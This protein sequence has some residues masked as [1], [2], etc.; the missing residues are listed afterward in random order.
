M[1]WCIGEKGQLKLMQLHLK[2][3]YWLCTGQG[4]AKWTLEAQFGKNS[5]SMLPLMIPGWVFSSSDNDHE[6]N[7]ICQQQL[8]KPQINIRL[9]QEKCIIT[10]GT[11]QEKKM[12]SESEV[13]VRL[14]TSLT[15]QVLREV[16]SSYPNL[17]ILGDINIAKSAA[18]K[19][20]WGEG[21]ESFDQ[22]P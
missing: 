20:R 1:Q 17:T 8:K 2:L 4:L 22:D 7:A 16:R 19:T 18:L 11:M 15:C 13:R 3:V 6:T 21:H 12:K 14:D 10:L 9:H 5:S